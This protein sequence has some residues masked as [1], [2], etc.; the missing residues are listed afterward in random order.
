MS[1][2][3]RAFTATAVALSATAALTLASS[4]TAAAASEPSTCTIRF[5]DHPGKIIASAF[6]YRPGPGTRYANR[7]F[8]Y[9]GDKI[10]LR[11]ARGSWY[12]GTLTARSKSGLRSGTS[13]WLHERFL[14]QLA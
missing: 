12:Y 5:G 10:K 14:A 11:C 8:L 9:R 7:G 6:H 3:K 4:T 2:L 1:T 13:G